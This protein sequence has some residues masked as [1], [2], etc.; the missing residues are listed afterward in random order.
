MTETNDT[1][2]ATAAGG[3][4]PPLSISADDLV[5]I[6]IHNGNQLVAALS[7]RGVMADFRAIQSHL[8]RMYEL[9]ER[10]HQ[11]QMAAVEARTGSNVATTS[12]SGPS[13]GAPSGAAPLPN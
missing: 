12:G 2:T 5:G 8:T 9:A 6:L 1:D 11:S 4:M 3:T 10:C 13:A 7:Q